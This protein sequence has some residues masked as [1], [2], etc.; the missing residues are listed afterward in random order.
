MWTIFNFRIPE[1]EHLSPL[2]PIC[3]FNY[4]SHI[5][6]WQLTK[7]RSEPFS[8]QNMDNFQFSC[9]WEQE[10]ASPFH[11]ICASNPYRKSHPRRLNANASEK[12]P[13][14]CV[15]HTQDILRPLGSLPVIRRRSVGWLTRERRRRR[16]ASNFG[17]NFYE[18]DLWSFVIGT[19]PNM[20]QSFYIGPCFDVES[21]PSFECSYAA[22][23][24]GIIEIVR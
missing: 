17:R 14:T 5:L 19:V 11:P 15:E 2:H 20:Q 16:R 23:V 1:Q 6:V 8:S 7:K 3:A 4:Y 9:S 18:S 24:D 13:N 22:F 10:H 21:H 12:R